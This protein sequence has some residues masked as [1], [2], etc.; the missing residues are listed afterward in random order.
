MTTIALAPVR[1]WIRRT[2]A[3]HRDRGETLGTFYFTVLFVL[4]VGGMLHKQLSAVFW[5]VEPDASGLAGAS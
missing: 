5:P 2:Q 4:I 3:A 1:R